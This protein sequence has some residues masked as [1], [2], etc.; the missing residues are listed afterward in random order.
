MTNKHRTNGKRDFK[1][2]FKKHQ[3]LQQLYYIEKYKIKE[4]LI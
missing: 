3:G 2:I 1:I 4:T